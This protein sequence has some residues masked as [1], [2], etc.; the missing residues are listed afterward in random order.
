M[1]PSDIVGDKDGIKIGVEP[2]KDDSFN[3]VYM[4]LKMSCDMRF[5]TMWYFDMNRIRRTCATSF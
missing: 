1:V 5:P 3:I 2:E 4:Y